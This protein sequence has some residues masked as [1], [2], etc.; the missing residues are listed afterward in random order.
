MLHRLRVGLER[1]AR[2]VCPIGSATYTVSSPLTVRKVQ[3]SLG[4]A[5]QMAD[6]VR[7]RL[8]AERAQRIPGDR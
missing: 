7:A 1:E 2:S 4:S 8:E 3:K 5:L 6:R